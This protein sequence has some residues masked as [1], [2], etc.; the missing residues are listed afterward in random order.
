MKIKLNKKI[1]CTIVAYLTINFF[2]SFSQDKTKVDS[3]ETVLQTIKE[4]TVSVNTLNALSEKLWLT[5]NYETALQYAKNALSLAEKEGFIKGKARACY[6][7]GVIYDEQGIY[8]VALN[9]FLQALKMFNGLG[10]IQSIAS[11][12]N[13]I[14]IVYNN[15]GNYSRALKYYFESLKIKKE[16]GDKQGVSSSLI[17]IANIYAQ[18]GEQA[19]HRRDNVSA[20]NNYDKAIDYYNQA[21][22]IKDEIRDTAGIAAIL[23][24]IGNIY[25]AWGHYDRATESHTMA[26]QINEEIGNKNGIAICLSNIGN[27][28][29]KLGHLSID[30]SLRQVCYS[31][32]L[33][34]YFK[35]LP[36]D[37]EIGN[38]QGI[39]SSLANIG[40]IYM[41]IGQFDNA[42]DYLL[43]AL[44]YSDSIE[45]LNL[46]RGCNRNLSEL[47]TKKGQ[48]KKAHEYHIKY[49]II[50]DKLFNE[51]KSKEIGKMEAEHEFEIAKMERKR[52]EEEQA[53]IKADKK[54]KEITWIIV[55]LIVLFIVM[56]FVVHAQKLHALEKGLVYFSF[57]LVFQ[58]FLI[59]IE[60]YIKP[61]IGESIIITLLISAILAAITTPFHQLLKKKFMQ[62]MKKK[63]KRINQITVDK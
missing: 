51:E 47:Y 4:D 39:I 21:H 37:E 43:R 40:A 9:Y 24:N 27:I 54:T 31:K 46:Q 23:T 45:A 32:A 62:L 28:Y 42:E 36:V 5:G 18:Q 44:A 2:F 25:I 22:K 26:L 52:K 3:I 1:L 56:S 10:D 63:E 49:S 16:L 6:N 17:K 34:Y 8:L 19:L 50:K 20:G 30:D 59:N 38:I 11:S 7:I 48:Y 14:G 35:S 29:E 41:D 33:E 15:Q 13:S 55:G 57:L 61:W 58:F 60:T 53:R 12:Y